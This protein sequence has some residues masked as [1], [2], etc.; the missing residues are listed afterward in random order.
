M[1][2]R[3]ISRR[4]AQSAL[5]AKPDPIFAAIET[6][7]KLAAQG[8]RLFDQL[9]EAEHEAEKEHGRRPIELISWRGY[10]IGASEIETRRT[11]LL[12]AGEIDPATIELEYLDAK[13]RYQTKITAAIGWDKSTSLALLRKKVDALLAEEHQ[14]AQLLARTK[15]TTPSGAG[16]LIQYVLNDYLCAD[17][18]YW[19]TTALK[20]AAYTLTEMFGTN[21][22]AG[23]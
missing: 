19:H 2:A 22:L 10:T 5:A 9:Q 4:G 7:E 11:V 6:H 23:E 3:N 1:T 12:E 13:E 15:P 21:I 14:C 16:A 20:T 8:A 18:G 17:E